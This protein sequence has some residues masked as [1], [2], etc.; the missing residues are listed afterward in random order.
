MRGPKHLQRKGKTPVLNVD[1]TR[2][3][4]DAIDTTSLLSLCDRTLIGLM[5]YTCAGVGASQVLWTY[6]CSFFIRR[7]TRLKFCLK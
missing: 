6:R 4:L 5:V 3:L 2:M 1:E 7:S